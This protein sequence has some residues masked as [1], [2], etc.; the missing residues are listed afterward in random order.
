MAN[1]WKGLRPFKEP[2]TQR[3]MREPLMAIMRRSRCGVIRLRRC[4]A[5]PR[6]ERPEKGMLLPY[7]F[8]APNEPQ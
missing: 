2:F 1:G 8:Q 3:R 6:Y 5:A 7:S 4:S